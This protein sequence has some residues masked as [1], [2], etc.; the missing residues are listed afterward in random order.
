MFIKSVVI[1]PLACVQEHCRPLQFC[2]CV[3]ILHVFSLSTTFPLYGRSLRLLL[4]T[5][6][7]NV[8]MPRCRFSARLS[9]SHRS[10]S[11]CLTAS[12]HCLDIP[13]KWTTGASSKSF[14]KTHEDGRRL[15]KTSS[16]CVH[17]LCDLCRLKH[18]INHGGR[19]CV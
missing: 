10:F 18:P 7:T 14:Q 16:L 15:F 5:H 3:T 12:T 2:M 4:F 6:E 9:Y 17:E 13:I 19:K 8:K 11:C 1:R